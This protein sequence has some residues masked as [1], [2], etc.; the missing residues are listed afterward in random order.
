[1][2]KKSK[3]VTLQP[4]PKKQSTRN[5]DPQHFIEK[6]VLQPLSRI[7]LPSQLTRDASARA[8]DYRMLEPV[9]GT[10]GLCGPQ[11]GHSQRHPGSHF[12]GARLSW[13]SLL[14]CTAQWRRRGIVGSESVARASV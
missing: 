12:R 4:N 2:T 9:R 6:A 8:R 5:G 11:P 7:L 1:M 14:V 13:G 10:R 3:R